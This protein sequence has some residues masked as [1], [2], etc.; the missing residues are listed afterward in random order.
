MAT[1]SINIEENLI[2]SGSQKGGL[3]RQNIS[4]INN[5][6]KRRM[7]LTSGSI[8]SIYDMGARP[9]AGTFITSSF[10]YGR[11]TNIAGNNIRL[12]VS[13]SKENMAFNISPGSSFILSTS[14]VTGSLEVGAFT[15][16]DIISVKAE[17]YLS[18]SELTYFV[19]ST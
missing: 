13:A 7:Q 16:D 5:F 8:K 17:P 9:S 14:E 11:I 3:T 15:Y 6:D 10:R 4:G 12:I 2:L 19:A 1:L 18:S